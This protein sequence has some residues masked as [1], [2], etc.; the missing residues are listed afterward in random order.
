MCYNLVVKSIIESALRLSFN[1]VLCRVEKR[2][3][4]LFNYFNYKSQKIFSEGCPFGGNFL[5]FGTY[6]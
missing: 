1:I 2:E 5:A 4:L 3:I 6:G